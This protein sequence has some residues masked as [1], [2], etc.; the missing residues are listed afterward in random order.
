MSANTFRGKR[1][2][3]TTIFARTK[4]EDEWIAKLKVALTEFSD[5]AKQS[6]IVPKLVTKNLSEMQSL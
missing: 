1:A 4:I 3:L 2:N 5:K 6:N